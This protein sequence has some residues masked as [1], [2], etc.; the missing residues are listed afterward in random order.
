[1]PLELIDRKGF[2][3]RTLRRTHAFVNYEKHY[4]NLTACDEQALQNPETDEEV[5]ELM[6]R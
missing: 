3:R 4:R 2:D 5:Q 1:M 6:R